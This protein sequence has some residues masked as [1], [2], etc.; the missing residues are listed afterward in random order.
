MSGAV[1]NH[2]KGYKAL[3]RIETRRGKDGRAVR[4]NVISL[5]VFEEMTVSGTQYTAGG[6][7]E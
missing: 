3:D 1:V 4:G 6:M 5:P 2:G 7:Q